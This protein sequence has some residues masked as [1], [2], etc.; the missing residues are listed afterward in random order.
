MSSI[1]NTIVQK[2]SWKK[3]V[4][5][6]ALFVAFY[7]LV[8]FSRVGVSGLLEMT[9]GASILDFEMG[10]SCEKAFAMLAALGTEGRAFYQTVMLPM[11]FPFPVVYMLCFA[12]CIALLLKS[13]PSEKA[14]K[15]GKYLLL[16]PVVAMLSD[17]A[18]NIGILVM[19]HGYPDLP[20]WAVLLA[21]VSGMIKAIFISA[22]ILVIALLLI[23]FLHARIRR[24]LT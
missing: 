1:L 10:Y 9:G 2:A 23:L 15:Y 12:S 6:A 7:V 21:S 24:T 16:V 3:A 14:V 13:V 5:F 20:A 8:N 18:E 11:D 19:L 22:S 17:W 4:L